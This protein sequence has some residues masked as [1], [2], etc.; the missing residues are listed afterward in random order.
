MI[1]INHEETFGFVSDR[2]NETLPDRANVVTP[3]NIIYAA[4]FFSSFLISA[5]LLAAFDRFADIN[6][7]ILIFILRII[8]DMWVFN[9]FMTSVASLEI[10]VF[11]TNIHLFYSSLIKMKEQNE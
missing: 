7:L 3:K 10:N 2:Q 6:R 5:L 8:Y 4:T 11:D 9:S 1:A